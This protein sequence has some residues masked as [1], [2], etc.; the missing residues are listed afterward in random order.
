M[1]KIA[2]EEGGGGGYIVY[3]LAMKTDE[4]SSF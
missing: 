3:V 4:F 1:R 2:V